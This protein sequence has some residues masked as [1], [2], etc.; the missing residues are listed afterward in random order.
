MYYSYFQLLPTYITKK[1]LRAE[2]MTQW[3]KHLRCRC[4]DLCIL[5][6]THT[7]KYCKQTKPVL[8]KKHTHT[9]QQQNS[10]LSSIISKICEFNI[11]IQTSL[12]QELQK[13]V[14][15]Y[16]KCLEV[17]LESPVGFTLML[18]SHLNHRG[19]Q[20]GGKMCSFGMTQTW[21]IINVCPFSCFMFLK[22]SMFLNQSLYKCKGQGCYEILSTGIIST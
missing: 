6:H 9:Q 22:M 1:N 8:K 12:S 19:R 20:Q 2:E 16:Y 15:L 13:C 5:K 3:V 4:E 17:K 10:Y 7:H 14:Q 11:I 21:A 18:P